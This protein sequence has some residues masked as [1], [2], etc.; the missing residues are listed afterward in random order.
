MGLEQRRPL[1]EMGTLITVEELGVV[2]KRMKSNKTPGI[3][4][5]TL[6]IFESLL[7]QN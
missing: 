3:D 4:V 1:E 2:L 5:I 7:G 6:K